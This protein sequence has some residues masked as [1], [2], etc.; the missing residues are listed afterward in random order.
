[1]LGEK[2]RVIIIQDFNHLLFYI[3]S[4]SSNNSEYYAVDLK[5]NFCSCKGFH[6]GGEP[7]NS[8]K[9]ARL[10]LDVLSGKKKVKEIKLEE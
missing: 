1:M 7:F 2:R 5:N 4:F 9:H 6:F 8:H 10:V 3:S